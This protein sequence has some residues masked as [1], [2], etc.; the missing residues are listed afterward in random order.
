MLGKL[1]SLLASKRNLDDV[2]QESNQTAPSFDEWLKIERGE[3]APTQAPTQAPTNS[4]LNLSEA[5]K[6]ARLEVL[7]AKRDEWQKTTEAPTQAPANTQSQTIRNRKKGLGDYRIVYID[8]EGRM[9]QRRISVLSTDGYYLYSWCYLKDDRRT[10]FAHMV[11]EAV[12]LDT[13]EV[14]SSI[15]DDIE[16]AYARSHEGK[17]A[18]G[19]NTELH[20]IRILFFVAKADGRLIKAER[21]LIADYILSSESG[22]DLDAETLDDMVKYIA[23]PSASEFNRL[24]VDMAKKDKS[25]LERIFAYAKGIVA[26]EKKVNP[27]EEAALKVIE[28]ALT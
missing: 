27:M 21:G 7:R 15:L 11:Q 1:F 20:A 17:H 10:F 8:L 4:L 24:V 22:Y 6:K 14:V 13:G 18:L 12:N 23:E 26:T 3:V 16:S 25:K 2:V 5:D 9:T 19:M 28:N